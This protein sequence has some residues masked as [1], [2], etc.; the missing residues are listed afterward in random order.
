MDR[1]RRVRGA[2]MRTLAGGLLAVLGTG[3]LAL[4]GTTPTGDG[5][6]GVKKQL[7]AEFQNPVYATA[8]PAVAGTVYVVEQGGTVQTVVNGTTQPQPF[9]DISDRVDGPGEGLLSIAFD[10][11]YQDNGF[12]YA[13]Y[14]NSANNIEIDEFQASSDTDGNASSRRKVI[15]I[16]HPFNFTHYGGT[17]QFG[18]DGFLYAATGDGGCCGDPQENAQDKGSLLG[19]V[20]RIDPHLD[21]TDPY[22]SPP[23]NPFVDESGRDEIFALGLR[24]PFRFSFDRDRILIGDVGQG[25]WEEVDYESRKSLKRANFGW[26]NLEGNH[27]YE[28]PRTE[29]PH[30][31][32]PIFEYPHGSGGASITGG[33]VSRAPDLPTI[34]GRYLYADFLAG[35]VRSLVPRLGG[36]RGDRRLGVRV[37][38]P[39]SFSRGPGGAIY[40]TSL[41]GGLYRL[42][43][44]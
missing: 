15:E 8:A 31:E 29:P 40:V 17:I 3:A 42:V 26:D 28:A 39:T 27:P 32:P 21:G 4:A 5:R 20:L 2:L 35:K 11:G 13:Y 1:S 6:G 33:V 34:F 18:T 12:L 23:G 30:Y 10:P 22:T 38:S 7:V 37:D 44:E 43:P 14:T 19:K 41:A 16:Q 24:N 25:E 9:L 36:A